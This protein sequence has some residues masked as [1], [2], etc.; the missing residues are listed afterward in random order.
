MTT[1]TMTGPD[2]K[3]Y[4]IDG[5]PGAS[6]AEVAAQ[7]QTQH[8]AM[9]TA[10]PS[11]PPAEES[12]AQALHHYASGIEQGFYRIPQSVVELGARGTDA[13]GITKNAQPTVHKLFKDAN[14]IA[15]PAQDSK[16]TKT[17]DVV[18][19]LL[20]TAPVSGINIAKGTGIVGSALNGAAQ[21]AA[22]TALTSSA[23]DR[24]LGE[25]LTT[26][27]LLGGAV[28]GVAGAASKV[29][30]P[31]IPPNVQKLLDEGVALTPGQ[32]QGGVAK[33]VEDTATSIPLTGDMI[34]SAQRNSLE[35]FNR[36]AINRTLK[37]IGQELPDT[38]ASGHDAVAHA[39][40]ALDSAYQSVLPKLTVTKDA[41]YTSEMGNLRNLAQNLTPDAAKQVNNNID[42]IDKAFSPGAGMMSGQT[43]KDI[44]SELGRLSRAY[45]SSSV[46]SER[47]T[48]DALAEAQN[49]LRDT[50]A[51][52][53]PAQAA[54]LK[55]INRGYANLVRVENAASK[56]KNGIFTPAQLQTATRVM[57][58]S[59]R[60]RASARGA[61]LMQD[62]AT[63]GRDVLPTSVPD[64]G[65]WTRAMFNTG[66]AG[67]GAM[68]EPNALVA[69]LAG[70]AAY[71]KTGQNALRAALASRPAGANALAGA[72]RRN[73]LIL[74]P[75]AGVA[76]NN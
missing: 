62:L 3:D 2:G 30:A 4:S 17:G 39:Q 51:R 52:S 20:A 23:S 21:G 69:S 29:I 66:A 64:S 43:M 61:S 76:A 34:K 33:R 15:E 65:T 53:N 6:R 40:G 71:T 74:A 57:D 25:Q 44:D 19:Q 46:G 56:A 67:L 54:E 38:V 9:P 5:P 41:R 35:T 1:Y 22:S 31:K 12:L 24:P 55:N 48:G 58:S 18:G 60:K 59:V 47:L 68:A 14:A 49:I 63:A 42:V 11:G 27:A 70:A 72:V 8:A 28:G 45:R 32:I 37:P 13:V 10:K 75:G 16:Y 26:G 73:A 36:A 7:M 50:V